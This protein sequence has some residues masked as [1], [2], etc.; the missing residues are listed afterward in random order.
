MDPG[1]GHACGVFG[2]YTPGQSV[3]QITYHGL[4]ALP[5]PGS[6]VGRHPQ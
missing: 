6:G 4:Y 3:A 5:T 1:I 2:V